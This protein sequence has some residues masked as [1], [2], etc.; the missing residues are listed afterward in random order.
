MSKPYLLL[1]AALVIVALGIGGFAYYR[2]TTNPATAP[3][4]TT[5]SA[6]TSP[7][8]QANPSQPTSPVPN[9]ITLTITSPQNGAQVSTPTITVSGKTVPNAD[10]SVNDQDLTADAQGNFSTTITLEDG[11]NNL[12]IT[13]ADSTGQSSEAELTV[14][15][16]PAQ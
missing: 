16:T 6:T 10:V 3:S 5:P 15:Y 4:Y 14:T 12:S 7:T 9:D 2:S 1:I 11:D 13:A 8:Q